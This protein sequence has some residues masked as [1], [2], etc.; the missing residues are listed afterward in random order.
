VARPLVAA[1]RGGALL[2]PENSLRAFRAA[3]ALGVD[4]VEL[5]VHP[6]A[7]GG[8]V[9]V[10]D[11]TLDRT[12]DG[13][14]PVSQRTTAEAR[15]LRLRGP[16]GALT[17][18]RLPALDDVLAL[19]APTRAGLLVEIKGP[20]PGVAAVWERRGT[21]VVPVGRDRYEGLEE[22]VL[23]R[24]QATGVAERATVMAFNPEVLSAV[25]RRAPGQR[26]AL[27]VMAAQLE[28]A[29]GRPADA[30][31]HAV[32]LGVRDLG[33][34]WTLADEPLVRAA[35][36]AE[37]ALGVWTVNEETPLRHVVALGVAAVTTDR[38][39]LALRVVGSPA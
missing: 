34:Q 4:L 22:A 39:D 23:D 35:R 27:L 12:T 26:T 24:L 15:R 6:T 18:E 16:D 8:L 28:A 31:A 2:W 36:D 14:G 38:P 20:R 30:L 13:S 29:G 3:L 37:V 33:V 7:D 11:A 10:H 1:H 5:D 25:H 9:V 21:D 17:D 19:V 32:A